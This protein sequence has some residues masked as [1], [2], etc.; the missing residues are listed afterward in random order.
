MPIILIVFWLHIVV[1]PKT[2]LKLLFYFLSEDG[3]QFC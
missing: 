3:L 2:N 1:T